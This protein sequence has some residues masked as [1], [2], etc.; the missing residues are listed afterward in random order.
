MVQGADNNDPNAIGHERLAA[1]RN[2][3]LE[4]RGE[5]AFPIWRPCHPEAF[6]PWFGHL[7][8]LRV[9]HAP[10]RY[11]V[12]LYGTQVV[13]YTGRDMTGKYMDA[14]LPS[15]ALARTLTPLDD[16]VATGMPVYD[17]F[18]SALPKATGRRLHR[19]ILPF[20]PDAAHVDIL[21]EGV[22]VDGWRYAGEFNVDDLY[23][24]GPMP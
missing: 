10:K 9:E 24:A 16:A 14:I 12:K 18:V 5:R 11:F 22:Y 2:F 17:R 19:L 6:Q 21:L 3:W 13:A 8:V 15:A 1:L 4:M 23:E 7:V 20:G